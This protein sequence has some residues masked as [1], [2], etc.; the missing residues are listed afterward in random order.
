MRARKLLPLP[1]HDSA[2]IDANGR[3]TP[4]FWTFL[5]S[6]RSCLEPDE[7]ETAEW[8][9]LAAS[10]DPITYTYALGSSISLTP[11]VGS[12]ISILNAFVMGGNATNSTGK[13]AAW[14]HRNPDFRNAYVIGGGT[15]IESYTV[16]PFGA[17][18]F[19]YYSDPAVVTS[20][21][22]PDFDQRYIDDPER[23][24]NERLIRL[25]DLEILEV[26][27]EVDAGQPNATQPTED[28]DWGGDPALYG[29][30]RHSSCS[31]GSWLALKGTAADDVSFAALN[32]WEEINDIHSQRFSSNCVVPFVRK[33]NGATGFNG[34]K[35]SSGSQDG[36]DLIFT[37]SIAGTTLTVSAVSEGIITVGTVIAGT[38]V[39][40][41][42]L[43]TAFGTG[44]GRAG[45]YTV[46]PSQTVASTTMRPAVSADCWGSVG[47]SI[48]PSDW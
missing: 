31:N 7:N 33:Q 1:S 8:Q 44:A 3:P 28:F 5:K 37:A 21:D 39:T 42:T 25:Y 9:R 24:Y 38:G 27:L 12:P 6:L 47:W 15:T 14:F 10:L 26:K 16:S 18:D 4:Q 20:R 34:I 22:S 46:F 36:K 23:L 48:L 29:I 45:T 11:A 32:L 2:Y 17:T 43:I 41:D 13:T 35:M 40:A 30:L 19:L